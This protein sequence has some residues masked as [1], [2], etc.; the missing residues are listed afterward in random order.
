MPPGTPTTRNE[1]SSSPFAV[2]DTYYAA[3]R[4][5]PS[6]RAA[7]DAQ[8]KAEITRGVEGRP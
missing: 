2:T 4:R 8:L 3:N 1:L 6:A 7:R 5:P